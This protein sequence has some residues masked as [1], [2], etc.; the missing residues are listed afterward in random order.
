MIEEFHALSFQKR[1][2]WHP[3]G[4]DTVVAFKFA[5]VIFWNHHTPAPRWISRQEARI[6]QPNAGRAGD[7]GDKMC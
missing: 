7:P 6:L 5:V 1:F 2:D 4:Q 3:R